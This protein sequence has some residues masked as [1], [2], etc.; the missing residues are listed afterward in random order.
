MT[1]PLINSRNALAS[2]LTEWG[3]RVTIN[4]AKSWTLT[5]QN[6]DRV[7]IMVTAKNDGSM[8]DFKV[9]SVTKQQDENLEQ[10]RVSMAVEKFLTRRGMEII[11]KDV[12][13]AASG[14]KFDFVCA[15]DDE[16]V[17]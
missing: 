13:N 9:V 4:T 2:K 17:S 1:T 15:E 7:E 6:K 14:A 11:A 5:A 12:F 16:I 3:F 8:A 10:Q